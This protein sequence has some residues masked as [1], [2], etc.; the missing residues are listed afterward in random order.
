M[1]ADTESHFSTESEVN[2]AGS[3]TE[4]HSGHDKPVYS[5][6]MFTVSS[7]ALPAGGGEV[8]H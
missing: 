2:G 4:A 8:K 1:K 5:A 7:P 6:P 3:T